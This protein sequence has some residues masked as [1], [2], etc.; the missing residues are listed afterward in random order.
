M[1]GMAARVV[2]GLLVWLLGFATLG[3]VESRPLFPCPR[4]RA[5]CSWS[6]DAGWKK[7]WKPG[8]SLGSFE[9]TRSGAIVA[10]VGLGHMNQGNILVLSPDY[11]PVFSRPKIGRFEELWTEASDGR[12][13]LCKASQ[14]AFSNDTICDTIV[15]PSRGTVE[16][17]EMFPP[18]CLFPRFLRGDRMACIKLGLG[19]GTLHVKHSAHGEW[20]EVASG[21]ELNSPSDT[22]P[23]EDGLLIIN[24]ER[25]YSWRPNGGF[26]RIESDSVSWARALGE[27][28]FVA[29]YTWDR[30]SA[31]QRARLA[32]LGSDGTLRRLW[33]GYGRY[34]WRL[35]QTA[36]DVFLLLA[37]TL[38]GTGLVQI[39]DRP[40]GP[41]T[42][43]VWRTRGWD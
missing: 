19:A 33:S 27:R 3:A 18:E 26:A 20:E 22:V 25:L 28:V 36:P 9:S 7:V 34:A 43:T 29:T 5:L 21:P 37:S 38:K 42:R 30:S 2:C 24:D 35:E 23:Y 11:H 4:S 17:T 1:S 13:I 16:S 12:V 31:T 39:E 14:S 40:S 10:N 15:D 8:T 32:E 6:S 41:V